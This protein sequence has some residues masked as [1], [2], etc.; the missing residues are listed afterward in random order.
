MQ[1]VMYP[2]APMNIDTFR[3]GFHRAWFALF[4]TPTDDLEASESCKQHL[5]NLDKEACFAG[6]CNFFFT[7]RSITY[8]M[9]FDR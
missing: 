5:P 1:A 6:K 7:I 8:Y 3:Q 2:D 9:F 4:L